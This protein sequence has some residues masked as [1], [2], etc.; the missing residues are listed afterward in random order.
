LENQSDSQTE[1]GSRMKETEFIQQSAIREKIWVAI[2]EFYLDVE[3]TDEDLDRISSVFIQ[4]GLE[5]DEIKKIDLFEVFPLLQINLVRIAGIWM[6]FDQQWLIYECTIR[7]N[8]RNNIFHKLNCLFWNFL[9]YWMRKDY[10][11]QIEKR[12]KRK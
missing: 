7:Y 4:S 6:G 2:S 5:L 11:N 10:W 3:L 9:F 1:L 8:R 12:I